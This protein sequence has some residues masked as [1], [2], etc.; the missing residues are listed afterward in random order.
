MLT[1]LTPEEEQAAI[2]LAKRHVR[3]SGL[4]LQNKDSQLL[5]RALLSLKGKLE[6]AEVDLADEKETSAGWL[7]RS[8]EAR[9]ELTEARKKAQPDVVSGLLD[10]LDRAKAELLHYGC[11]GTEPFIDTA[12]RAHFAEQDKGK[13]ENERH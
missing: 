7:K 8:T 6:E 2:E 11:H 9:A 12:I 10:A 3:L 1:P 4:T 13:T 5:A